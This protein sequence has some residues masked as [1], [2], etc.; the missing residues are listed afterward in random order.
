MKTFLLI[1]A[2]LFSFQLFAKD[3]I[4][5]TNVIYAPIS[6]DGYNI[7]SA[8]TN[9]IS[10]YDATPIVQPTD[11][12]QSAFTDSTGG[13]A[14]DTLASTVG[15]STITI[16]ITL[17]NIHNGDVLTSFTPGYKYKIIGFDFIVDRGVTTGSK[18]TTL[19]LEIDTND[20][21]GGSMLLAS[22]SL[23]PM[24]TVIYSSPITS[25]NTGIAASPI[26][27]EATSTT[28]FVEGT[29]ALV[30]KIQNMDVANAWAAIADKWNQIRSDLVNLGLIAGE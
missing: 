6:S 9:K 10:F 19:N 7:G 24:G 13:T 14:S 20:V 17:S 21:T 29:G 12:S 25:S 11:A 26:S 28:E 15:V 2:L 5:S 16:P 8:T 22:A 23:T 1:L 30:L 27:I 4:T 18:T 3:T